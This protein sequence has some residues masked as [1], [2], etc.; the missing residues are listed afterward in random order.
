MNAEKYIAILKGSGVL[1]ELDERYGRGGWVFHDDGGSSHRA[2]ITKEFLKGRCH[3]LASGSLFWPANS[4]DINP[5]GKMWAILRDGTNLEGYT[6][7]EELLDRLKKTWDHISLATVNRIID[8][9]S[10]FL[11]VVEAFEGVCLNGHPDVI[12]AV[13]TGQMTVYKI[14][15]SRKNEKRDLALFLDWSREFLEIFHQAWEP[16]QNYDT[17]IRRSYDYLQLLPPETLKVTKVA[18]S[19]PDWVRKEFGDL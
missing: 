16:N 1:E 7:P 14:R 5:D 11:A 10:V 18:K 13:R 15:R 3:N 6:T 9:F 8:T 12:R 4:P 17:F 2:R 19:Y